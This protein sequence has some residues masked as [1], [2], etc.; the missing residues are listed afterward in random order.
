MPTEDP[1]R[2][3]PSVAAVLEDARTGAL[4]AEFSRR[5]VQRAVTRVLDELRAA[6]A[7]DP[8][9]PADMDHVLELVSARILAE[10][11]ERL[12]PTV[13]G[14]GI[15]LHTNL[16]RAVLPRAA[17]E[18]LGAMDRCVN[19]QIDL[20]TGLRGKR[21]HVTERLLCELTG[22]EAAMI[23]NNNAAATY[24]ILSALCRGREVIVSRGQLIE[25]GGSYRLPDCVHQSGARMREVGATNRTHLRDYAQALSEAT[26]AIL[27]ANP[28]NYRMVGFTKD[29]SI[30]EL[31]TLKRVQ[32]VLLIDDLGCG[33]LI[34]LSRFGLPR[35]PTV[36]ESIAAGADIV[37]FSGDKLIG[38][39]QAGIIVGRKDLL[40]EIRRHPLTRMLRVCKL[41][42][43][44]LE[45][46]LRLFLDPETLVER[47]P[48][49]RM[50]AVPA[51]RL[52]SRAE[53]LRRRLARHA[54][55]FDLRVAADTGEVG[56][57]SLPA[58]PIPTFVLAVRPRGASAD[59]VSALLR[60][61]SPPVV[62]R[63]QDDEVRIDM[64]T[65]LEGEERDVHDALL[66]AARMLDGKAT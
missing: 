49:F 25:I 20:G 3:L 40:G 21:N 52:K 65:L 26:G 58:V 12:R 46:T 9:A 30:G 28:S 16:G 41:T 59:R 29:V 48:T 22:A 8:A 18:A 60:R 17:V 35:E 62:A 27:R 31:A 56:G 44:V 1:R 42:D 11:G 51:G 37:C 10:E 5:V 39:A 53:A 54:L 14:T 4:S 19:M 63:I 66:F 38:G 15:L 57:G 33:A 36:Q 43:I 7:A 24:L 50:L 34:D 32:P 45:H 6:L 47:H 2:R 23:V 55:P 64:R 13:N 61:H